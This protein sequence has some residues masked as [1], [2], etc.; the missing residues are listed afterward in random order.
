MTPRIKILDEAEED[1]VNGRK[2]Y[3]K[4]SSGLGDYFLDSIFSDIESLYLYAGIHPM[5]FG[6]HRQLTRRFP[7]AIYYKIMDDVV[8]IRAVLDSRRNPADIA[9]RF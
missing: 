1:L 3:E 4:Q 9:K 2:F 7:Y 5:H 8:E 6:Y